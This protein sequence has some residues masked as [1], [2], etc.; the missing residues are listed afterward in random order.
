MND[1]DVIISVCASLCQMET[2]FDTFKELEQNVKDIG[3]LFS[4][5]HKMATLIFFCNAIT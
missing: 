1:N 5:L 3:R 2:N 4:L